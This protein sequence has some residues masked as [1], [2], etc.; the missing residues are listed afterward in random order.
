M[1]EGFGGGRATGRAPMRRN[2]RKERNSG[3]D[4]THDFGEDGIQ[5]HNMAAHS[6]TG[7]SGMRSGKKGLF[8]GRAK[9]R[10]DDEDGAR[11]FILH[12]RA[13][14]RGAA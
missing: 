9:S 5:S 13:R 14:L 4:A 2:S 12:A 1:E 10:L 6:A 7:D 11:A 8:G 3:G